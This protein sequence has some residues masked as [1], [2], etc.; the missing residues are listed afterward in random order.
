MMIYRFTFSLLLFIW[1]YAL[2]GC[3]TSS[4]ESAPHEMGNR[5][6]AEA[7]DAETKTEQGYIMPGMDHGILQ[8]PI[9]IYSQ[10]AENKQHK[11]VLNYETS[12]ESVSNLGHTVQVNYQEGSSIDFD[13]RSFAFKQFHFH[14]PSE[15]K[16][17]GITYPLEM[18]MVHVLEHDPDST[19]HYLV[20]GI[21]FKEGKENPFFNEFMNEIPK[22]AGTTLEEDKTE[23]NV[24]HL[25]EGIDNAYYYYMGSLT[26]PPYTETVNWVILKHIFEASPTQVEKLNRIEGNNARHIQAIYGRKVEAS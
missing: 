12:K 26:T 10:A 11:I 17:D 24:N 21:L 1:F 9:N 3:G 18:H 8:S 19:P 6:H 15:H 20:V 13:G 25:F 7:P 2:A 14:T 5:V 23:V 16:I 4:E 22:E